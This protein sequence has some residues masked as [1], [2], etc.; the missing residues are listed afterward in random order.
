MFAVTV[1]FVVQEAY[2]EAF[3]KVIK[4]QAANSLNLEPGCH[5]FD[6]CYDHENNQRF[7]L[8]E[9]Y[10]DRDAFEKHLQ[11]KHFLTFDAK[12]KDWLLSKKAENW[13]KQ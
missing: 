5:Q 1:T 3:E 11:T 13:Q 9:L 2:V 6:V 7:F 4:A 12:V 10:T 8:Y